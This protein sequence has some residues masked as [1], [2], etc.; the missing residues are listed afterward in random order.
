MLKL[1]LRY[2]PDYKKLPTVRIQNLIQIKSSTYL[3]LG[4]S[5]ATMSV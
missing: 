5:Y 2:L 1:M 4:G 3:S